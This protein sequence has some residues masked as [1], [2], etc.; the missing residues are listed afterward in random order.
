MPSGDSKYPPKCLALLNNVLCLS[1][2]QPSIVV[3]LTAR[4]QI[5]RI[6]RI[7]MANKVRLLIAVV[8]NRWKRVKGEGPR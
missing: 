7:P 3:V 8:A 6:H 5:L 2:S 4:H 1:I